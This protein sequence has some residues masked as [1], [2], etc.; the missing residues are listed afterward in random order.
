VS[1]A[2]GGG[3]TFA[4]LGF[5]HSRGRTL[6]HCTGSAYLLLLQGRHL[7]NASSFRIGL[8]RELRI[9]SNGMLAFVS[10]R[11]HLT[12]NQPYPP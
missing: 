8:S 1:D 5:T 7:S 2:A 3:Q 4:L 10:H 6:G 9:A 11:W 12:S